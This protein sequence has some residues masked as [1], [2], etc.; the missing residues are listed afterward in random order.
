[1]AR[2]RIVLG[3]ATCGL[4]LLA[5][6]L[7]PSRHKGF[8]KYVV[9]PV[10]ASVDVTI[11]R[12]DDWLGL[13]PEPVAYL[14]FSAAPP[15]LQKVITQ[16]GFTEAATNAYVPVPEGPPGW[17]TVEQCGP[18]RRLFIRNHSGRGGLPIGRNRSWSEF[19]WIDT[20]GT[21]AYF[22]LWGI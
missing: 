9:S 6:L 17:K 7:M 15:D 21:N 18:A 1:M 14:K 12:V 16:G 2:K 19:L 22:L 4:V 13:N 11:S 3:L 20:T 5:F 8:A 10:P